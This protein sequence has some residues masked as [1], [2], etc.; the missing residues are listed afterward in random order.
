MTEVINRTSFRKEWTSIVVFFILVTL[1]TLWIVL[2]P[3]TQLQASLGSIGAS[4]VVGLLGWWFLRREGVQA[5]DVGL[6]R[7]RWLEGLAVFVVW[8]LLVTLVDVIG[9]RALVA[10]GL[11]ISPSE[12]LPWS[13]EMAIAWLGSWIVVGVTEEIAFRAYL[14]NKLQVVLKHRWLGIVLAALLFSLWHIPGSIASGRFVPAKL[15]TMLVIAVFSL[16]WFNLT[17]EWTALLPFLAL[18]HG[19]SDFPVIATLRRPTAIGAVAGYI[20]VPIVLLVYSKLRQ[21]SGA[22][23]RMAAV[24]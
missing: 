8:W 1:P 7:H 20:L 5:A 12:V 16:L 24:R 6:G 22:R 23:E 21:R 9:E 11:S 14:H 2:N 4:L 10:F 3:A 13:P 15:L 17:Y 19:W 18:F